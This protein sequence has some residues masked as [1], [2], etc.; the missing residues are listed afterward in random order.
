MPER[1]PD[2]IVHAV[3]ADDVVATVR[4]A[5]ASGKRVSIKSGGHSWRPTI[6]ATVRS[7]ST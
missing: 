5:K 4:Y 6:C 1:Y 7:V 2:V 3:D